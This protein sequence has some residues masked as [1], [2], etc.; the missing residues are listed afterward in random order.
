MIWLLNTWLICNQLIQ[1]IDFVEKKTFHYS[2]VIPHSFIKE[3]VSTCTPQTCVQSNGD[4]YNFTSLTRMH[5]FAR[6]YYASR[7]KK[8]KLKY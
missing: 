6:N 1:L 3:M 8:S 7:E 4:C 5:C 2:R